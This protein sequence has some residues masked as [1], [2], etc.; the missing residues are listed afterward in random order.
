MRQKEGDRQ[1]EVME[2]RGVGGVLPQAVREG[3]LKEVVLKL[4]PE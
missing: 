1:G 2:T 3:S 4:G